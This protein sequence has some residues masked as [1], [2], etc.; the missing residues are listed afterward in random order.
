MLLG[1]ATNKRKTDGE[2]ARGGERDT[3]AGNLSGDTEL[4]RGNLGGG[5]EREGP[6]PYGEHSTLILNRDR[7]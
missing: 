7:A 3:R 4:G 2:K 5:R 1:G 6:E